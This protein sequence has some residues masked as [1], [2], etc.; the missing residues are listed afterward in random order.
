MKTKTDG[1]F[2]HGYFS[3]LNNKQF[4]GRGERPPAGGLFEV[5]AMLLLGK[6]SGFPTAFPQQEKTP[7]FSLSRSNLYF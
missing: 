3:P 2:F 7:V 1:C 5:V 6:P 4:G